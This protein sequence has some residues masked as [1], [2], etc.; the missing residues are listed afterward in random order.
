[1]G[2]SPSLRHVVWGGPALIARDPEESEGATISRET[3]PLLSELVKDPAPATG[4]Q[5]T[6]PEA[7]GNCEFA[8]ALPAVAVHAALRERSRLP[9]RSPVARISP[10]SSRFPS[11]SKSYGFPLPARTPGRPGVRRNSFSD[12]LASPVS[13][14]RLKFVKPPATPVTRCCLSLAPGALGSR[15]PGIPEPRLRFPKSRLPGASS[16]PAPRPFPLRFPKASRA[17]VPSIML[18]RFP[19]SS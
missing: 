1:M 13:R 18:F 3:A 2:G 8:S 19:G 4:S 7:C 17:S 12:F 15:L 6:F 5:R 14:H 9:L 10:R 16:A 11:R